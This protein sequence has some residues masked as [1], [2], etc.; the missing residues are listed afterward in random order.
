MTCFTRVEAT[1]DAALMAFLIGCEEADFLWA[2]RAGERGLGQYDSLDCYEGD[3]D[4][5][6]IWGFLEGF[7]Y[8][9]IVIVDGNGAV[10]E[11]L[12]RENFA[13]REAAISAF[14]RMR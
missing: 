7:W 11:L 14:H 2:A 9:A 13:T 10:E 3:H 12:H 1:E 5:A 4:R 6:A 8:A